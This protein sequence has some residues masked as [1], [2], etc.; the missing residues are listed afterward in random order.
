[1]S[2]KALAKSLLFPGLNLHGRLRYRVLP[3]YFG[4]PA[5]GQERLFLDAGCGNGMLSYQAWRRGNRVIGVSIKEGEVKRA[6]AFFH[7]LLHVPAD[8]LQF[9]VYNLYRLEDL[10]MIF[11]EIVCSEVLEHIARDR[12][13]IESFARVLKPGGI[14]N[15]CAPNADHPHHQTMPLDRQEQG[16]HVRPGYTLATYRQILE[17]CG[18]RLEQCIGI[19]G[20][21]RQFFNHRIVCARLK[22]TAFFWF[23][24]A[25]PFLWLDPQN[26]KSPYSLY[27][28]AVKT[29]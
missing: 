7:K 24:L 27:V 1:M 16:G 5:P 11:D 15:L 23:A 25:L 14:L 4:T 28:R 10:G 29:A 22:P 21:V 20:P 6:Q 19:G 12:E 3:R 8:R 17:P 2:L 18:F 26:P 9:R 13:V